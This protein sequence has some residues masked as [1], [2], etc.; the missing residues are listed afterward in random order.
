M[1]R[2]GEEEEEEEEDGGESRALLYVRPFGPTEERR[3]RG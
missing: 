3:G 1:G 2:R